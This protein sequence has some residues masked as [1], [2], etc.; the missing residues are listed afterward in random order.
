MSGLP[1]DLWDTLALE[2]AR[3]ALRPLAGA[4]VPA[5]QAITDDPAVA[6]L[7]SFLPFPFTRADALALIARNAPG[8]PERF[9]GVHHEGA[10]V[11][12]VG[13]HAH[14]GVRDR[15]A[16]EI[17][18][19]PAA[20]ARGRG[21]A[22]EAVRGVIARLRSSAPQAAIV[23]EVAPWNTASARLLRDLGFVEAGSA[24]LRP[25]RGLMVL[26]GEGG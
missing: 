8:A 20:D 6:P 25:G 1:A 13:A 11:G 17:G 24:G 12:V 15:P 4:D 22:R 14:A 16:V 19:W 2:T 7:I 18:Y 9:L 21:Y 23:A 3:L 10:L 5:L 26:A